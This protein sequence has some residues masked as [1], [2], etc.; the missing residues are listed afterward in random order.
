VS[1]AWP[2]NKGKIE[3]GGCSAT[4]PAGKF[5][6]KPLAVAH[7]PVDASA[8]AWPAKRHWTVL[9]WVRASTV[10]QHDQD[11]V[12]CDNYLGMFFK[13]SV[14]CQTAGIRRFLFWAPGG[15]AARTLTWPM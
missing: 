3:H 9:C 4:G 5:T 1:I 10:P 7:M 13:S 12:H 11:R 8:C 15:G 6:A 2:N 14:L